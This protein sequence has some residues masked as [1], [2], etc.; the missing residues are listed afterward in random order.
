M[1][2]FVFQKSFTVIELSPDI[3]LCHLRTTFLVYSLLKSAMTGWVK[4]VVLGG[5]NLNLMEE[6]LAIKEKA[7]SES[8][9]GVFI[10]QQHLVLGQVG[11]HR[12]AKK[13]QKPIHKI[14]PSDPCLMVELQKTFSFRDD[15]LL[16]LQDPGIVRMVCMPGPQLKIS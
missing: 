10:F 13:L 1:L 9:P 8:W 5:R 11:L 6:N 15:E 16:L 2:Y 3:A 4:D 14:L 12:G 7:S